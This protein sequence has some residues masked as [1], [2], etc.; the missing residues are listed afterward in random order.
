MPDSSDIAQTP[1]AVA[2]RLTEVIAYA[3]GKPLR[4]TGARPDGVDR[5]YVLE[6]F[7]KCLA[8]VG[9]QGVMFTNRG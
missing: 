5:N 8:A 9:S 2:M 7:Q 6:L 3:E 1:Y 4:T